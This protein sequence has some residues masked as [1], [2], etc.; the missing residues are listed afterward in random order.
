MDAPPIP[1]PSEDAPPEPSSLTDRLTNVIAAP[2]E[3]FEDL[4]NVPVR[5]ANWLVP[6]ILS[7]LA[8]VVYFY[9]AFSQ[10]AVLR[11]MQEQQEVAMDKMVAEGKMNQAQADRAMAMAAQIMK[12][13]RVAGGPLSCVAGFFLIDLVIWIA[14]KC[15]S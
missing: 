8:T 10:P 9:V 7:C 14:L 11:V 3:A 5:T 12:I 6:L 1:P 15:C 2:G 4:K 13:V